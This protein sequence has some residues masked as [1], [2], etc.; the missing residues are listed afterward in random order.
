MIEKLGMKVEDA[1][2]LY[3][4][5]INW[6]AVYSENKIYCYE[7]GCDFFTK[8]DCHELQKHMIN[9]HNYGEYPCTYQ[10]CKYVGISKVIL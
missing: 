10:D 1:K 3:E 7:Q 9:I 2:L 8:I 5:K 4:S 6:T